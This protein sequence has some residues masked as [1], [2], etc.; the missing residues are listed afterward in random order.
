MSLAEI[1]AYERERRHRRERI[2]RVVFWLPPATALLM[3]AV[4]GL[5]VWSVSSGHE[6]DRAEVAALVEEHENEAEEAESEFRTAWVEALEDSSTVRVE[7]ARN[8]GEA[9]YE[10]LR[11]AVES[12]GGVPVSPTSADEDRPLAPLHDLI[13]EGLPGAGTDTRARLGSFDPVLVGIEV[14]AYSYFAY[15]D[16]LDAD[17]ETEEEAAETEREPAV[18]VLAVTWTTSSEGV[19]DQVDAYWADGIPE[20]S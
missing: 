9:M 20:S 7:R 13:D 18:A 1:E 6:E 14:G 16:V 12:E 3:L 2:R 5:S 19:I 15:V 8:D 4:G 11:E 17:D 10:S